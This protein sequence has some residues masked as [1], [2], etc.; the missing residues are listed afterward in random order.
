MATTMNF[1]MHKGKSFDEIAQISPEYLPYMLTYENLDEET[2]H[3]IL[4]YLE[5]NPY[6]PRFNFGKYKGK[7]MEEVA[8]TDTEYLFWLLSKDDLTPKL[9]VDIHE[10]LKNLDFRKFEMKFGKHR[11]KNIGE[12]QEKD[13]KYLRNLLD[14]W[15]DMK[16]HARAML[17]FAL[18]QM[19]EI[20][21]L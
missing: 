16:P 13:P 8:R 5:K 15:K 17:N 21:A 12:V 20:A 4:K 19:D 6:K 11:G 3:S 2:K 1:G 9:K 10:T 18:R 14:M 7:K